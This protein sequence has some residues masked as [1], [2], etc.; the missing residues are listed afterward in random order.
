MCS[1]D[2][3][4]VFW[5]GEFHGLYSPWGRKESDRTEQLSLSSCPWGFALT[6]KCRRMLSPGPWFCCCLCF[7]L[8]SGAGCSPLPV[9]LSCSLC[10]GVWAPWCPWR[11]AHSQGPGTWAHCS[12]GAGR[13]RMVT[14]TEVCVPL[15]QA[16]PG[17]SSL[18][19][20]QGQELNRPSSDPSSAR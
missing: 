14:N 4:P 2:L 6:M 12:A 11:S 17:I 16:L 1:S 5:P 8:L 9:L 18:I 10:C 3:T 7:V 19:L 15:V 13:Y 20:S